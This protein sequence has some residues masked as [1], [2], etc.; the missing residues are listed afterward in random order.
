MIRKE[1]FM[2]KQAI[3]LPGIENAREL[4]G[5]AV[6]GKM[7][8]KGVLLRTAGLGGASQET[9]DKLQK[10]FGV[11]TVIDF[12]MTGER[13]AGPDP[14]IP[15]AR[16]IHLPVIETEDYPVKADQK[17]IDEYKSRDRM[18]LFEMAY[19]AGMLGPEQYIIFLL[20]ERG[21]KAYREFF[22][23]LLENDPDTG[24]V[25][26]HCTDGKDR[27][28]CAAMLLLAALG[29]DRE[30]IIEDYMLTNE[31]KAA[32]IEAVKQKT[33]SYPMPQEKLDALLFMSGAVVERYMTNAIDTLTEKYGS[34][35]G[36]LREAL[37]VGA[38][39]IK[40]LRNKYLCGGRHE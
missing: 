36:Y 1:R 4:G 39:E 10:D 29:A 40:E 38:P 24:A 21:R 30:T 32:Q 26:W 3:D 27:T 31:Y 17:M 19:A 15:G 22:R 2:L 11:Q 20:G 23:I 8:K 34:I 37:N 7:I 28:G 5:Y 14:E 25:L 9:I 13:Y 35:E 18:K 16:N 12:R 33:A 6:G